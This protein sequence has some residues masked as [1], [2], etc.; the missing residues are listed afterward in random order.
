MK[1]RT[2][3]IA[4]ALLIFAAVRLQAKDDVLAVLSSDMGPY[5]EALD[6][7]QEAFGGPV[8][9]LHLNKEPFK[10][11]QTPH[12]V[13]AFGGKAAT[14]NYPQGTFLIYCMA[15]GTWVAPSQY[16][17]RVTKIFMMPEAELTL[18][19]MK[20]VQPELKRLA[21]LWISVSEE[22]YVKEM[23]RLGASN[24]ITLVS[25]PLEKADQLPARLRSL[26]GQADAL[27]I[28]TDPLLVN[29]SNLVLLA[30]FSVE[31]HMPL[32]APISGL[33][34]RGAVATISSDYRDIGRAA[35]ETAQLLVSG[36][37]PPSEMYPSHDNLTIN[38]KTAEKVGLTLGK[39]ALE[40]AKKV[41]R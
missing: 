40:G 38:T 5:Q 16:D 20:S 41:I 31:A 1:F 28:P 33:A 9:T 8:H 37:Q 25:D 39:S 35:A 4:A 2:G 18:R 24:G 27:W 21:V 22:P 7:F 34:E 13:V 30:Q 3:W 6:G 19:Q 10:A 12:I 15:P 36:K 29:E 17:G 26:A 14:Q 11:S 23:R 32:Y